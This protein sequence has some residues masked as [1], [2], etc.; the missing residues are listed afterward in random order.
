MHVNA[1]LMLSLDT[2]KPSQVLMPAC[3]WTAYRWPLKVHLRFCERNQYYAFMFSDFYR[4]S[5][6]LIVV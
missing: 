1:R 5:Y 2:D 6:P 4:D 3:A